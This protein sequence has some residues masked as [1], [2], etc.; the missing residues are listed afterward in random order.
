M[1]KDVSLKPGYETPTDDIAREFYNPTL[2]QAVSYDRI[3]G[4]F[5][6]KSLAFFSKGIESLIRNNGHYRLIISSE[7]SQEDYDAIVSGYEQRDLL[8]K[9]SDKVEDEMPSLSDNKNL[10]NLAYLIAIGLV[11]IRIGFTTDGLFHAK[12]GIITDSTGDSV[13]F[14]G[15]F[16]E[17]A[18]AFAHNY[19]NID[20]KKSW[21][22]L[23]TKNYIEDHRTSFNELWNG[24]NT[25]RMLFVKKI[26]DVVKKKIAKYDKG[27]LIME[28]ELLSPESLVLYM[29]DKQL[30]IQDN[31]T[32]PLQRSRKLRRIKAD[33]LVDDSGWNFKS[34]L[35]YKIIQ[36]NIIPDFEKLARHDGFKFVVAKSVTEFIN[37]SKYEIDTFSKQGLNIKNED[38]MY[39]GAIHKFE[40]VVDTEV[41]RKLRPIQLWVSFYMVMMQRVGN[42][43]VPGSGKTAMVYGSYAYLSAPEVNKVDKLV[44]I[45]PKSSFLAWKT[46]FNEVFGDKRELKCLNVQDPD[47][48]EEQ[49]YKNTNQYNLILVN[50]ESLPKYERALEG[51]INAKT[52]LVFDEVHK[53]KG[54][55]SERP[56]YA[57]PLSELAL[58]KF[59]LTGTPI[60]NGY[61][62][63]YNMLHFLYKDEYRDYFGFSKSELLNADYTDGEIINDKLNPFFWRVTKKDL[64]VPAPEPDY[65]I[66]SVATDD[67][68]RVINI[69]WDKYARQPFKLYIRLIQMASNPDLLEKSINKSLFVDNG[70]D[71]DDTGMSIDFEYSDSMQDEPDYSADELE[72][73]HR[74]NKSSKFE[75]AIDKATEIIESNKN[76][77]NDDVTKSNPVVW[78]IFVDT[79]DKFAARMEAKGYRVAK[80]Y[81]SVDPTEREEIIK[82]FQKHEYDMLISNPHTLAESVSLHHVSHDALYL[83]YSFNLTHMLQSRDRIH[84][85]GLPANVKTNYYYFELLGQTGARQPIDDLIYNRLDKKRQLMID[86]IEGHQIH[87]EFTADETE[88]ITD[89][90]NEL[91]KDN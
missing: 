67:E 18:N 82:K 87:P 47:F 9:L 14:S 2:S 62:D 23:D 55:K 60:P 66:K 16:N 34:D 27:K 33:F 5:S 1:L 44:V 43:S 25:D 8:E 57:Q 83:E 78:A 26:N 22:D 75:K 30:Y 88:E 35:S 68:Q 61:I 90:M 11:D 80:V 76:K 17:T 12:Y 64:G 49:L 71:Q 38:V 31:L 4:Y 52:L 39:R 46:E 3:S 86:T 77:S 20:I 69:L 19:E 50:Y 74:L 42:F 70:G 81:G 48:R 10:S 45:G 28:E 15:S 63:I 85:L 56:K 32:K 7:I 65:M 13:Y 79:I 89:L 84:R 51:I 54:V 53:L 91:M 24:K 40:Q 73:L 29:S 41:T 21:S 37:Q 72:A 58:Y 59:A 36:D 6:S